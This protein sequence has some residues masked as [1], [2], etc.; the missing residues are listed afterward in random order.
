MTRALAGKFRLIRQPVNLDEAP[1]RIREAITKF[2]DKEG[3]DPTP[4]ELAAKL[5][6]SRTQAQR[7]FRT[8]VH[9]LS[10]DLAQDDESSLAETI[11]ARREEPLSEARSLLDGMTRVLETLSPREREVVRLR[12]GLGHDDPYTLEDIAKIYNLSR[13]R[14]RQIELKALEKLRHPSRAAKLRALMETID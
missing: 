12:F 9:C 4:Y 3:R 8:S 11:A 6:I 1:P 5:D 7:V 14:V 2:R 10:L 13:E